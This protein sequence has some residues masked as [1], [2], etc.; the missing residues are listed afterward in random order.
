MQVLP[1]PGELGAALARHLADRIVARTTELFLLGWPAGRTPQVLVEPL[2]E[3]AAQGLDLSSVVFVGMD[4]FITQQDGQWRNVDTSVH[5]SCRAWTQSRVVQPLQAAAKPGY[6]PKP[7]AV[8]T[9][10][11]TAPSEYEQRIADAGGIELF[12]VA[13]G[14]GDGHVALNSSPADRAS[15]T[16]IVALPDSTKRDNLRTFPQLKSIEEAP[17]HGVTVGI[18]TIAEA[19]EIALV[20]PGP[21]KREAAR[22]LLELDGF[23]AEWPASFVYDH[24]HATCWTDEYALNDESFAASKLPATASRNSTLKGS[25]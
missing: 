9:P 1:S 6:G 16:R 14:S 8:W 15:R 5:F 10:S 18:A 22:R 23:D 25:V 7:D 12:V 3:L 13:S 24:P 19:R 11:P 2:C 21:E 17:G 20:L 4:E